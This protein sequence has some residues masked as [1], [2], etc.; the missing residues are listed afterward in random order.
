MMA[1]MVFVFY[2]LVVLRETGDQDDGDDVNDDGEDGVCVLPA[3]G[4]EW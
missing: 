4:A 2:L 1:S 3:G